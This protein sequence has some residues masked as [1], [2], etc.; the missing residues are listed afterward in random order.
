MGGVR[1]P[2]S[3]VAAARSFSRKQ[4]ASLLTPAFCLAHMYSAYFT[5]VCLL[6]K[7]LSPMSLLV[8]CSATCRARLLSPTAS[9]GK[10]MDKVRGQEQRRLL[11]AGGSSPYRGRPLGMPRRKRRTLPFSG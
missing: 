10:V 8:K 4:H 1:E 9:A 2:R 7:S 3:R 11:A 6:M 5:T